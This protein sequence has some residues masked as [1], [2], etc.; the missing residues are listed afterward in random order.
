MFK[1]LTKKEKFDW[2]KRD[3]FDVELESSQIPEDDREGISKELRVFILQINH[4]MEQPRP[5]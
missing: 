1:K 3:T 2:K 4:K 5:P